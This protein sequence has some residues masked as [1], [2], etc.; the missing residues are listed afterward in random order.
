MRSDGWISIGKIRVFG[1]HGAVAREQAQG[2]VFE[3]DVALCLDLHRV[4]RSD[5]LSDTVDYV[6]VSRRVCSI[7]G[8]TSFQLLEGLIGKVSDELLADYPQVKRVVLSIRKPYV[9]RELGAESV[10]V[11][12]DRSR[13]CNWTARKDQE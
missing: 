8:N 1:R 5:C 4:S 9:A 2:Q 12:L 3:I 13:T 7:V 10:K 6:E 11:E